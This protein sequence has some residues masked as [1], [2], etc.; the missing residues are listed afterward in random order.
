MEQMLHKQD[1]KWQNS[2]SSIRGN[3]YALELN[4]NTFFSKSS[5]LTVLEKDTNL[6]R[7]LGFT[8]MYIGVNW[9]EV[10]F[11]GSGG[12]PSLLSENDIMFL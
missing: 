1:L 12:K 11:D 10:P 2:R 5:G 9:W 7:S 8:I 4:T 6:L 3:I